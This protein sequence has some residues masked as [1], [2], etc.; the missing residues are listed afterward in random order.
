MCTCLG[1]CPVWKPNK[2]KKEQKQEQN[3]CVFLCF[4]DFAISVQV[5]RF[6]LEYIQRNAT[7]SKIVCFMVTL[8]PMREKKLTNKQTKQKHKNKKKIRIL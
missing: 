5:S 7:S 4:L 8:Q 6:N 1:T 2:I 3:K